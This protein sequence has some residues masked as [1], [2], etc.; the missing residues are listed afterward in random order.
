MAVADR[1]H[2]TYPKP[3]DIPCKCGTAKHP[4]YPSAKHKQGDRWEVIWRDEN[5]RLRHKNFA[6]KEG[7]NPELHADAF[8][9]KIATE[10]D[11]GTYVDP[12]TGDMKFEAFA[13][14]WR[15]N[16]THGE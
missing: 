12:A 1:W 9:A 3:D 7:K 16:R 10:L 2:L 6:K 15:A 14:N 5:K 13:E 8:D 4:L 11:V